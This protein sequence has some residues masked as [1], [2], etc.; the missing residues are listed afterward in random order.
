PAGGKKILLEYIPLWKHLR[1]LDKVMLRNIF[2]YRQRL[3]MMIVGISG[4]TAL[5]VTGFGIGDSIKD[6][7]SYQFE[8]VTLY[9]LQVQFGDSLTPEEE[10][11]I[12]KKM[13]DEISAISFVHQSTADLEFGDKTNSVNL[14]VGGEDMGQF[15]DLHDGSKTLSLP[16]D[17]EALVSVGV[18]EL[19]DISAGDEIVVRNADSEALHLTV[20]GVF[21][22]HVFN[23]VI[24]NPGTYESQLGEAP[25]YQ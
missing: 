15:F 5:L 12:T 1:F 22:N 16:G 7:V 10:Q 9:D 18:A 6:I 14:L 3:L 20:S 13:Q 2:R 23:Y 19:L 25:E 11:Q 4:C 17:G 8:E 21:D 24:V